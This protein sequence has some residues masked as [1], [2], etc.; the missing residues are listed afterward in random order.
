[1]KIAAMNAKVGSIKDLENPDYIFEPKLDGIRA[2]CYVDKS[3][4]FISRNNKNLTDTYPEL[5]FRKKIRAKTAILDGEIVA[6]DKK[7]KP[8]FALLQAGGKPCYVVF[9]ILAKNGVQL[10]K[11]PLLE[12]KKILNETIISEG[13]G[14]EKIF[15]VRDGKRLWRKIKKAHLEGVMAKTDDGLYYPGL[16]TRQWLKIKVEQSIDCIIIGYRP[17]KR[18]IGSLSLGLYDDGLLTYIGNVGTGFTEDFLRTLRRRFKPLGPRTKIVKNERAPKNTIWV[19]PTIVAE[20]KYLKVTSYGILRM[21]VFLRIRK[22][23]KPKEC[24]F[25]DQWPG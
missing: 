5:D 6:Y 20:I 7:G 1:M 4:K 3:L 9:D 16:R 25:K 21:P 15:F 18:A 13:K 2:L 19:K 12:R 23:K 14:L 24:T 8:S 11:K 10:T 22:D 17:G